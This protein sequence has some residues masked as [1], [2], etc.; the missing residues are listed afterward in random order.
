MHAIAKFPGKPPEPCVVHNYSDGGALIQFPLDF[1]PPSPFRLVIEAKGL[2]TLCE[3]RRREGDRIGVRFVDEGAGERLIEQVEALGAFDAE[4]VGENAETPAIE[5]DV[6]LMRPFSR[7]TGD[8][9]RRLMF[10]TSA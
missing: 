2:D 8:E 1:D 10:G 7:V 6:R 9:V 5:R 4:P 3:V